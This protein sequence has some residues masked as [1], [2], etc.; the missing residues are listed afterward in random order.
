EPAARHIGHF[1]LRALKPAILAEFYQEIYGLQ[2][3]PQKADDPSFALTD[4]RVTLVVAPWNI[5]DYAGTGVERPAIDHL[6]FEVE[7]LD[8]FKRD[9]DQL[10]ESRPDLFPSQPKDL[11]EGARTIEIL[12]ESCH[13]GELHLH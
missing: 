11:T 10:M 2:L 8:A 3:E 7:S 6:G 4:G 5:L 12:A 9:L 1:Q 13:R